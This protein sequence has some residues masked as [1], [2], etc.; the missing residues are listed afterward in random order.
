MSLRRLVLMRH[1]QTDYNVNGRMQGHL[2]SMLTETGVEQASAAAPE[3]A[4][5]TP[6]RLISSDLR[7]AVDTADLV[8]AACGR[9][10]KL[11]ARLRETHLGEWQG[12]T[13]A[14]IEDGWP[15]AIAAWRSDPGWA[16]P[17]GESRIEVVRRSLPV[18]EELDDEYGSS[19]PETTVVLVAHGGLIA[20]L[21]CGLLALPATAWPAIGGMGN[22]R[23]AALARRDDH[24]RWRLAG[25]NVGVGT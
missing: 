3:I 11:D 20:G 24:P 15:G 7:R 13:V 4:R 23:W 10:V 16:P 22:C 6:D 2:D 8:A 5:L 25:Y 12:R 19:G 1:G 14:E 9:P 18:V 17:G 21:V